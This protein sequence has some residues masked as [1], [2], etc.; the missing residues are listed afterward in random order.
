VNNCGLFDSNLYCKFAS[1][2]LDG[3][4]WSVTEGIAETYFIGL[5]THQ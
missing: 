1:Q 3:R 4:K 2:T 5:L